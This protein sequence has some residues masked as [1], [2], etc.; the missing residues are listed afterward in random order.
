MKTYYEQL[1]EYN[2]RFVYH[3][4]GL[5]S[6]K[7]IFDD[8]GFFPF[9]DKKFDNYGLSTTRNKN[10]KWLKHS[11]E[12]RITFDY[13]KLK[14][15]FKIKP[16]HWFNISH[17]VDYRKY[18]ENKKLHDDHRI[19][20]NQFEERVEIP[21]GKLLPVSYIHSIKFFKQPSKELLN[22]IQSLGIEIED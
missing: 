13:D 22:R 1:L 19:P 3:F 12:V 7:D 16:A 14:N 11:S 10:F 20:L 4:T 15:N 2:Q 9:Y 5:D 6:L 18:G 17:G 21:E 8:G